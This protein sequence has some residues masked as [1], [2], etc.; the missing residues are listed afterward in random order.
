MIGEERDHIYELNKLVRCDVAS[1][2]TFMEDSGVISSEYDETVAEFS[3][4]LMFLKA[5]WG[6]VTKDA[7]TVNH[8]LLEIDQTLGAYEK[9]FD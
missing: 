2:P 4:D 9:R 8:R 6:R 3:Q 7:E 1:L 5:E